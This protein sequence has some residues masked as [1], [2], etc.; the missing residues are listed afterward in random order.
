VSRRN[1][2]SMPV[3]LPSLDRRQFLRIFGAVTAAGATG[4]LTACAA[5]PLTGVAEQQPSGLTINIGL[6]VPK[7]GPYAKIGDDI[8]KGFN[9]FVAGRRGLLGPH[10]ANLIVVEEG[11]SAES[12][13]AAVKGLVSQNVVAI[14]GVA[15]PAALP[16]LAV[17]V[18]EARIPLV[19][20]NAAPSTLTNAL[21][22]WR[23]SSVEGDSGRSLAQYAKVEGPR[24]YLLYDETG[25]GRAE[26]EAFRRAF[27]DVGGQIAG[28]SVG[29]ASVANRLQSARN[30]DADS[31]FAS[32]SGA[33][34]AAVI[35]A[36]RA[37]GLTAKLLGTG[38]LTETIDLTK[39]G[40]LPPRVYTSM[41]YAADL[42]NPP[43]RR[44]V[45]EYHKTHGIQPSGYAMAAYDS[46]AVLDK[47]LGLTSGMPTGP[48]LNQAF[49]LLGQ[50]DSPRGTWTFNINR[51]P[52]QKWYLRRL[53]LDGMVPANML[54]TD[55]T[56]LG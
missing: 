48:T 22:V 35:D 32:Y 31:I 18:Q 37:S 19:S 36:Y 10:T 27:I 55:L 11:A 16:A 44:F 39:I 8:E 49:S 42:D 28:E 12:A 53:H 7:A 25:S 13:V 40:P 20:A 5:D 47:A 15:N 23:A 26:A 1:R 43:N 33:D 50:I 6:V 4:G 9:L 52:Q 30:N 38:S 56:V 24:A 34:A 54:D 3:S 2:G 21:F 14:A 41:Y 45:S 51:S 29:T 17:A 46:A